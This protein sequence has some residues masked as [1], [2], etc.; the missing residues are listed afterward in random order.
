[1]DLSL[2]WVGVDA[3]P[4]RDAARNVTPAHREGDSQHLLGGERRGG[5]GTG[6]LDVPGRL[7]G[8]GFGVWGGGHANVV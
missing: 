5:V 6:E 7:L 1:M 3:K 8:S 2:K 4:E